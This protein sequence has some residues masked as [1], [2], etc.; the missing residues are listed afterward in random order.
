M[1][2]PPWMLFFFL[3]LCPFFGLSIRQDD[4]MINRRLFVR[5]RGHSSASPC[6]CIIQAP[7][8]TAVT[9]L[10]V[11]DVCPQ[12]PGSFHYLF[13]NLILSAVIKDP[14]KAMRGQTITCCSSTAKVSLSEEGN[15]FQLSLCST[16][17]IVGLKKKRCVCGGRGKKLVVRGAEWCRI[18]KYG[19]WWVVT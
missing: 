6:P 16:I 5:I 10:S 3:A 11:L 17:I 4:K 13:H 12:T 9:A 7:W 8:T 2:G 15:V 18:S 1:H 19:K 14:L